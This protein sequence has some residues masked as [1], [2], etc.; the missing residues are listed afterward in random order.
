MNNKQY[1]KCIKNDFNYTDIKVGKLYEKS[2]NIAENGLKL[3]RIIDES[4]EDYLYPTDYFKTIDTMK[5]VK[6]GTCNF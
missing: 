5:E 1:L 3:V 6:N 2:L 4:G